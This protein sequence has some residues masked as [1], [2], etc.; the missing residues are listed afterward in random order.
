MEDTRQ[1]LIIKGNPRR[2]VFLFAVAVGFVLVSEK[3]FFPWL[4]EFSGH[5]HCEKIFG[6]NGVDVLFVWL[7]IGLT[8]GVLVITVWFAFTSLKIIKSGQMP[9]PGSWVCRDTVPKT[10]RSVIWRAYL[11][12][13][14][15]VF[16]I[17]FLVWGIH[18]YVDLKKNLLDPGRER[19]SKTCVMKDND[20]PNQSRQ[21]TTRR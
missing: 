6:F 17:V 10:G 2:C 13:V 9:P 12:L 15:P 3:W 20:L 19:I 7:F 5:A 16:G 21:S 18:A 11:G 1:P 8:S 4:R 14:F